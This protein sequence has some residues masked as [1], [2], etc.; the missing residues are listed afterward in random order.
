MSRSLRIEYEG[1]WYHVMNRGRRREQVFNEDEDYLLFMKMLRKCSILFKIEIHAYS[2]MP[3][4]YHLLV[5]TPKGNL[6]RSM[7]HLNGVFTQ[8]I[9][10]KYKY[11]GSLFKG[12]YKAIIVEEETYFLELIRYIH[13]NPTKA[14][15]V[16]NAVEHKWT[17]HRG[18]MVN[19]ER[20]EWLKVEKGLEYFSRHEKL[21]QRKLDVFIKDEVPVE[22]ESK[23]DSIRWPIMFGGEKF[24]EKIKNIVAGKKIEK[25]EVPQYKEVINKVGVVEIKDLLV[26]NMSGIWKEDIFTKTKKRIFANKKKEFVYICKECF[27]VPARDIC[28]VL[29]GVSFAAVS[30]CY[31]QAK[32]MIKENQEFKKSIEDAVRVLD[33][34]Q[35]LNFKT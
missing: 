24:K 33:L 9:N 5:H 12:R 29:G 30:Y 27:Q 28:D 34:G 14:K 8:M 17:S 2:L 6:S 4:H 21:A 18:Y 15:L 13:K 26:K 10:K 23:L 31:N 19:K 1:A 25:R 35:N 3:N 7:R 22:I 32:E 20:P 11:E 16:E